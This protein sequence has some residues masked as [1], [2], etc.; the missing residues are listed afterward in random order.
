MEYE[1]KMKEMK[2]CTNRVKSCCSCLFA[3][4]V[5]LI[6]NISFCYAF[7]EISSKFCSS[8]LHHKHIYAE[9]ND[10]TPQLQTD[11]GD[12]FVL[13]TYR[14]AFHPGQ[15]GHSGVIAPWPWQKWKMSVAPT[16]S[17]AFN[18]FQLMVSFV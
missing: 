17:T 3:R 15:F 12:N 16:T 2:F 14:R 6:P 5:H 4:Y 7:F 9:L 18:E 10:I 11:L 1:I 13:H 8:S